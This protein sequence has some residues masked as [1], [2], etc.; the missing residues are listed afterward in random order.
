MKCKHCGEIKQELYDYVNTEF[1]EM[2]R[3]LILKTWRPPLHEMSH[4]S[5]I[6]GHE[7]E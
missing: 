3:G 1:R 4:C 5:H 7:F 2:P 6:G